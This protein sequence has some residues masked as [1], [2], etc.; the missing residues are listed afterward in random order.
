VNGYLESLFS[1]QGKTAIVTGCSRGIGAAIAKGFVAAGATVVGLS[2]SA[3][4]EDKDLISIYSQCDIT[5]SSRFEAL[6]EATVRRTGHLDVLVNGAGITQPSSVFSDK[7]VVFAKTLDVNLVAAY[8]C[9][10][11]AARYMREG[12]SIINVTSIGSLQG[13]PG[14]PGY[15]A[16][17][18][19][20]RL[21]TKAL[22]MDLG[23]K[24]IRVNSLV[25]GYTKTSMTKKSHDNSVMHQ[26]RLSRMILKRWG[27]VEDLVGAAVFLASNAS[28]YMTGT[29]VIIDGGWTAKGL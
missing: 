28:S 4:P 23:E 19:G 24:G 11:V 3:H 29:D 16:S 15:V 1:L 9:A 2:R 26:E 12:G 25:P 8:R 21:L 7:Y 22:A 17:K 13:F 10:D 14:N 6:C 20:L 27:Q 18:G 5:D